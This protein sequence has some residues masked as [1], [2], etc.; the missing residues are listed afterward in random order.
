MVWTTVIVQ[1]KLQ[2]SVCAQKA[3][4]VCANVEFSP[5]E[6]FLSQQGLKG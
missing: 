2:L 5:M 4:V 6:Q 3:L 1:V